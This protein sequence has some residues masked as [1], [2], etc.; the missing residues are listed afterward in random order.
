MEES[1]NELFRSLF[2]KFM[3]HSKTKR[4]TNEQR[5]DTFSMSPSM[6]IPYGQVR[7]MA[8]ILIGLDQKEHFSD[9][10][11]A[12]EAVENYIKNQED[13]HRSISTAAFQV[14]AHTLESKECF[15]NNKL[16]D[17]VIKSCFNQEHYSTLYEEAIFKYCYAKVWKLICFLNEFRRY[18]NTQEIIDDLQALDFDEYFV[19][20]DHFWHTTGYPEFF[21]KEAITEAWPIFAPNGFIDY[22]LLNKYMF[23]NHES[24]LRTLGLEKTIK[25]DFEADYCHSEVYFPKKI[26]TAPIYVEVKNE[27]GRRFIKSCGEGK[28]PNKVPEALEF[29][30]AEKLLW[31]DAN[32]D[33]YGEYACGGD[34]CPLY[35]APKHDRTLPIYKIS[36]SLGEK[37]YFDS[38]DKIDRFYEKELSRLT[39]ASQEYRDSHNL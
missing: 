31:K 15:V 17:E 3:E 18:S 21:F 28:G 38:S 27:Y 8:D 19:M 12:I 10:S 26:G 1:K 4:L 2:T 23:E 22:D 39:I 7:T 29:R 35:Y 34:F 5:E 14:L 37:L 13:G 32:Y 33:V 36:Y 16:N 20:S 11:S 6:Y 30:Y 25:R 24:A 9:S